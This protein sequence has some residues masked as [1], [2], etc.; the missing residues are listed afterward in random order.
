[1][2]CR[3]KINKLMHSENNYADLRQL[4]DLLSKYIS[5]PL[6]IKKK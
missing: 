4:F 1:M 5:E 2:S 6:V 3:F